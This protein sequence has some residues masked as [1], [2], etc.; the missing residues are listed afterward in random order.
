MV[1]N[2][3]FWYV[4]V[5]YIVGAIIF[6]TDVT[7]MLVMRSK[8]IKV[9]RFTGMDLSKY[10][11]ISKAVQMGII[12][13]MMSPLTAWHGVLHYVAL[14]RAKLSNKPAKFWA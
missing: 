9:Q 12:L 10:I 11:H 7:I 6:V 13:V 2:I 14:V 4:V 1:W 8:A 3:L 5:S